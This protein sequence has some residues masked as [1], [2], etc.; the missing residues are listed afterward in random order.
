MKIFTPSE[1][2]INREASS[3]NKTA[4]KNLKIK[5]N[6]TEKSAPTEKKALSEKEIR[7][8]LAAHVETSN[9]AKSKVLVQNSKQFGAG[10]LNA[11]PSAIPEK[12]SPEVSEDNES[13]KGDHLLKSDINLNDP[14]D[15]NTQEKLKSVL[16]KGAFAFNPKEREAL[17]KI[18]GAN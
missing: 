17:E 13:T 1:T 5:S 3:T 2:N 18:L 11:D 7:E 14:K 16:Q 8:K 9:S 4:N 10:F 6:L 12:I 15:S